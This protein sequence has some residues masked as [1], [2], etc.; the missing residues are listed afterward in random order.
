MDNHRQAILACF[1][2]IAQSGRIC[3]LSCVSCL[4]LVDAAGPGR[5]AIMLGVFFDVTCWG[6]MVFECGTTNNNNNNM[7]LFTE[8]PY[9]TAATKPRSDDAY[10]DNSN[11]NNNSSSNSRARKS[12]NAH[13]TTAPNGWIAAGREIKKGKKTKKGT[14]KPK[15]KSEFLHV[16]TPE[17][18]GRQWKPGPKQSGDPA[19]SIVLVAKR[20]NGWRH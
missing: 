14:G 12:H 18:P 11:N 20:S 9:L 4:K 15:T 13:H 16:N 17:Q 1:A 8:V 6:W 5:E 7:S 10:D 2:P 19:A 3:V